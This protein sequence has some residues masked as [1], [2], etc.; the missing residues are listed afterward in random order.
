MSRR[1]EHKDGVF[2][3]VAQTIGTLGTCDRARVGAVLV[4]EGR[5]VSWGYNGAPPGM[6]HCKENDHGWSGFTNGELMDRG[7]DP[8]DPWID[9]IQREGCRNV[10]HAEANAISFAARQ[11]ISTDECT[12]YVER[13]PCLECA[14]LI[15]AAGIIRVVCAVPYRDLSGEKLLAEALIPVNYGS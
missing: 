8:T 11:G 7:F 10:T 15:I 2:L 6:P 5:C 4:R 9:A 12:L 14:R 1:S 3:I 13:T